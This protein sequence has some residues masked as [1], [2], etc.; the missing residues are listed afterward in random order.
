MIFIEPKTFANKNLLSQWQTF[1]LCWDYIFSKR[2]VKFKFSFYGL[3][4]LRKEKRQ[5]IPVGYVHL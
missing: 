1:K 5:R 2:N 3:K 4:W